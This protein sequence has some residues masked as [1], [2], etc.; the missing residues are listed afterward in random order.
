[1]DAEIIKQSIDLT[2]HARRLGVQFV[3]GRF[4]HCPNAAAHKNGD[5]NPS[6]EIL[7]TGKSFT[8][9]ACGI[10]GTVIDLHMTVKGL[11]FTEAIEDLAKMYNITPGTA[12][13]PARK[14]AK[15]PQDETTSNDGHT[16][17]LPA[18]NSSNSGDLWKNYF[19][20]YQAILDF[21][22][23]ITDRSVLDYLTGQ[24]RGLTEE[25]IRKFRLTYITDYTET[26]KYLLSKFSLEQLKKS[27][28]FNEKDHFLFYAH[29]II[30]PY[31]DCSDNVVC[32]R[33]R[34]YLDGRPDGTGPK[35]LS[36]IGV[37]M[38]RLYNIQTIKTMN[39]GDPLYL[40]EGEFDA[41]IAEQDGLHAVALPGMM[42]WYPDYADQL[43]PY[44]VTVC[45]DNPKP[46]QDTGDYNKELKNIRHALNRIAESFEQ[47]GKII[48]VCHLPLQYKDITDYYATVPF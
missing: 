34:Y 8:C 39:D 6:F 45:I 46:G 36:L 31:F 23:P 17:P 48:S 16:E 35:M 15:P 38:N 41:M 26:A 11:N 40:V 33:G 12:A 37:P 9:R 7:K 10:G 2:E 24:K 18:E 44:A 32:L 42:N 4:A 47:K 43:K 3:K 21:C 30:I 20:V 14:R 1:M 27:G 29:R 19:P 13:K 5:Q 28:L 22:G 25:S